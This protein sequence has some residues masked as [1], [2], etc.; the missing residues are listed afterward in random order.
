[1]LEKLQNACF[2]I[3]IQNYVFPWKKKVLTLEVLMTWLE[4]LDWFFEILQSSST[5]VKHREFVNIY[6]ISDC[7]LIC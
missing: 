6:Q 7:E 4:S 3:C 2:K 5:G 1:M